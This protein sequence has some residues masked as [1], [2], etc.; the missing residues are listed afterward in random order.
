MTL[1]GWCAASQNWPSIASGAGA[2]GVFTGLMPAWII[3]ADILFSFYLAAVWR[4]NNSGASRPSPD[5]P[6]I[7][8]RILV[9]M[10]SFLSVVSAVALLDV[11]FV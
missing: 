7:D 6:R 4:F 1:A 9:A 2:K 5:V 3:L 10:S 11:W 8:P